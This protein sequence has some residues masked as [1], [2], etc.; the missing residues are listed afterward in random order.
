VHW[1]FDKT[2]G[3]AL[4]HQIADYIVKRGLVRPDAAAS[5]AP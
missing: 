2:A 5:S 4:S 3:V 1:Q